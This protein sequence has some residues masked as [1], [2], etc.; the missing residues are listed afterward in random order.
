M[1]VKVIANAFYN[2]TYLKPDMIID[3]K[4]SKLPSWA[5][6]VKK[7]ENK[8]EDKKTEEN[9]VLDETNTNPEV[10][11]ENE[12]VPETNQENENV[13]EVISEGENTPELSGDSQMFE[14]ERAQYLEKLIDRAM[15]KGILI[16]DYD[17]K[18]IEESITELEKA[19][20]EVE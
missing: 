14:Y 15:E 7:T 8:K 16:D 11:N 2:L 6:P 18:P 3:F 4:G 17:K 5:V 10:K 19:L 20:K 1:K 12:N 9:N 13:S